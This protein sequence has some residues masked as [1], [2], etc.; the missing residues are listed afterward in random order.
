M[1]FVGLVTVTSISFIAPAKFILFLVTDPSRQTFPELGAGAG[2]PRHNCARRNLSDD[3][4]LLV[5]EIFLV[6]QRQDLTEFRRQFIHC[7]PN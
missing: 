1:S 7:F 6:S 5:R 2:E 4:Y 3:G